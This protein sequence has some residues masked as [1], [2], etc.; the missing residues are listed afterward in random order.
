MSADLVIQ[1]LSENRGMLQPVYLKT[2]R[3]LRMNRRA[4]AEKCFA[5]AVGGRGRDFVRI[6]IQWDEIEPKELAS[7]LI[8]YQKSL[9][10]SRITAKKKKDEM[11]SD[12][13]YVPVVVNVMVIF[14]N[15]IYVAY[16]VE[17]KEMFS[18]MFM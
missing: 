16:F 9:K 7:T 1:R 3:L 13:I 4:E 8:S 5:E 10:E 17:Q 6:L 11:I 12:L 18:R 2:L 15:F 14:M